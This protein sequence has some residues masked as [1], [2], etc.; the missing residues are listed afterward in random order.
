MPTAKIPA[1]EK[2]TTYQEAVLNRDSTKEYDYF[3]ML[4]QTGFLSR[5]FL[6]LM[7]F[8]KLDTNYF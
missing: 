7:D 8:F 5:H 3:I 6:K 4:L 1:G 2:K